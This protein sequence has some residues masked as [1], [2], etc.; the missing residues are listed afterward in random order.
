MS[1]SVC[2]IIGGGIGGLAA[3]L[4]LLRAGVNV[5]V[6]EQAARLGEVGAGLTLSSGAIQ[7]CVSLGLADAIRP[8]MATTANFA[9]LH[10]RTGETLP[11]APDAPAKTASAP[12][13]GHIYRPDLHAILVAAVRAYG[14]DRVVLGRKLAGIGRAPDRVVAHFADGTS[15][16]ADMLIGADGARSVVRRIVFGEGPPAFTG[17]IAY[18]FMLPVAEAGGFADV[19]GPACLFVGPGQ[20]FNRYLVSQG[21][22]LNCVALMRSQ[23]WAEDGWNCPATVAELLATFEGWH[24][25]VL[26]LLHRAP[27]DRLIKWGIFARAPRDNWV[28]GRVAL[29]GDAAHPMQP[30]LGLGAAMAIEDGTMLGRACAEHADLATALAAYAEVRIPRA[31]AVMLLSKQ[32]GDL[33]DSTDPADFPPKGAPSHNPAIGAFNP[34]S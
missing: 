9:Y 31:N 12:H 21:R 33:F 17:K 26:S 8:Y 27:A 30:F 2:T 32:Q 25:A 4:A 18:R 7:C 3:A 23:E 10:Y 14:D 19:G 22:L 29:L 11:P 6:Y 28:E 24:P 5:R 13:G 1:R 20:V 34:E 15:A 16:E